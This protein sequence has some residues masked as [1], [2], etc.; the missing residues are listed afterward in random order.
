MRVDVRSSIWLLQWFFSHL[1]AKYSRSRE[2]FC[3]FEKSSVSIILSQVENLIAITKSWEILNL[4]RINT[5]LFIKFYVNFINGPVLYKCQ[6]VYF[7]LMIRTRVIV[8]RD[9]FRTAFCQWASQTIQKSVLLISCFFRVDV[10]GRASRFRRPA[11][12]YTSRSWSR[13]KHTHD[14]V[15]SCNF[16]NRSR[17]IGFGRRRCFTGFSRKLDRKSVGRVF[18]VAIWK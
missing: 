13:Q 9:K 15:Y 10:H 18:R 8:H 7:F 12:T 11:L 2:Y 4:Q 14:V 1:T 3:F 17:T 6:L 5:R 16:S